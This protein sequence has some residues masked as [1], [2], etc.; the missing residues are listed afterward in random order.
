MLVRSNAQARRRVSCGIIS[1][2]F[3]FLLS[4][5]QQAFAVG[6]DSFVRF[7][8]VGAGFPLSSSGRPAPLLVSSNDYPGV[9]LILKDFQE[10]VEAATGAKPEIYTD[11]VP[12]NGEIVIVGTIGRSALVDKLV[13]QKK[14]D[15]TGISGKWE[16]YLIQSVDNPLP[17]VDRALVVAGSD[18][19]GTIFG[20]FE[21]SRQIGVSPWYW[22]ADVPIKQHENIYVTSGRHTDG[23]PSVKYRGIFLNDEWPDLT[24]WIVAKF[25]TAAVSQNPPVPPGIANYGHLFY[26][27]I[28]ELVLRL[29]GNYLWPA[30]WNNAFNEDDPENQKLADEYGIVMG[31]SHQEPMM[32]AQKEWDRRYQSTLGSWNFAKFPE[33]LES[34]WQEGI[35]RNKNYESI[36]TIGLRGANDTPMAPG[37][38]EA[39]M[40]LLEKIVGV[41]R[42][43]LAEEM[44]PDA[45]KV[46][47]LWCLYKEV[48][49]FYSAGMRVPD[50]VTLLWPDDNWGNVRRLPT[51][52]ERNR[53][54]GA[55][56]YYHFDYHGGPRNYQWIN[57]SPISK[58]WDQLSLAKEYG[59]DRIWI[60]NV[61]HLKGY[62]FP[63]EFFM[64]LAWNAD[65]WTNSNLNEYSELWAKEQFGEKYSDQIARILSEY[66]KFNG[67]HKP[68]LLAPKTY[69]LVDY[70]EAE[71]VIAAFDSLKDDA[72]K[73]FKE[74]PEDERDAFY[75]LVLF[76]TQVSAILNEMYYAAGR[77]E[78]YAKQGRSLTDSMA[79]ETRSLFSKDTS[80]FGYFN[81]TFA[82]GKWDHFMDQPV[83]GYTG[84]NQPSENNLGAVDLKELNL[85]AD[86]AMGVAVENSDEAWPGPNDAPELPRFDPFNEQRHHIDLFNKGKTPFEYAVHA[87]DPWIKVSSPSSEVRDQSRIWVDIDWSKAPQG[88]SSATLTISGTDKKV[89]VGVRLW[90]PADVTRDNLD[91]FVEEDGCVSIEATHYSSKSDAGTRKWVQIENYG[92]TLSAMRACSGPDDP[93]ADPGKDSPLL[94]Y[95]MFLTDSGK[96][97]VEGIFGPSLN[98]MPGRAVRYAVSFDDEAPQVV[99][100]VPDKYNAQNGNRDWEKSVADNARRCHT[101]HEISR[102]GYHTLKIWMIDPGIALEKIVVN[103]GGAKPSYLGPPE[104]FHRE[105]KNDD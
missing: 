38:P 93:P 66:T 90:N 49:D 52:G 8:K 101:A 59:A 91:G 36:V 27:K 14:I 68:E 1:I 95:K 64:D 81:R 34:F 73:I 58:I 18:K 89:P 100:L 7:E 92:N 45:T 21:I 23:P 76:P 82:G 6:G 53:P 16:A 17:G 72:E 5:P 83:I 43:I 65:R 40:T 13:Q 85:P 69:S 74:L 71:N 3:A 79:D 75:E 56:I 60:V 32:R 48:L 63:I 31:T 51:S 44:N 47:Q 62:E 4:G 87:S 102:V 98:F 103:F 94:E 35:R 25:G 26:E 11:T 86:A 96:I 28:F 42:N 80:L 70:D 24:N 61:G 97:D 22:W 99:A 104:S 19:R 84:W 105:V 12:S 37:G 77:N 41:Q 2:F 30:M 78:L 33:T 57:T 67:R 20:M 29:K 9:L 54:G 46:P 50:D 39:N 88:F 15:V 55:G 10:D